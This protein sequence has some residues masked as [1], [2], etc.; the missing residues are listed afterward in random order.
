MYWK[1]LLS[2]VILAVV[3]GLEWILLV[4]QLE[5]VYLAL[6]ISVDIPLYYFFMI[7]EALSSIMPM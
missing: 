2:R 1:I 5:M 6:D 7:S 3:Q 4:G